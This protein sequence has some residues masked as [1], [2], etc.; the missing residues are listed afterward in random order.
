MSLK[1]SLPMLIVSSLLLL[2]SCATPLAALN[3]TPIPPTRTPLPPLISPQ[4]PTGFFYHTHPGGL[5][6]CVFQLNQ[7]GTFSYYYSIYSLDLSNRKPSATGT[8]AI[9]DN[10]Y[11]EMSST[12]PGCSQ[13]ATY[14]WTYDGQ[15]LT[16][17][18]LGEDSCTERQKSYEN[19]VMFTKLK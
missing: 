19:P 13:P 3:R 5:S 7:D 15:F 10:L 8:Y 1:M 14:Y 16:F 17:Q 9:T 4:F 11:N 12:L 18:V 2:V 6:Y